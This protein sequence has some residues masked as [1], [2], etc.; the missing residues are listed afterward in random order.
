MGDIRAYSKRQRWSVQELAILSQR[1]AATPRTELASLFPSRD[2]RAV[3]CKAHWLGLA[4]LKA[5][6][7]GTEEVREAKRSHMARKRK[8]NPDAA[9]QYQRQ[10]HEDNRERQIAKMRDYYARRFFWSKAMRLRGAGRA[11]ARELAAIW[12]AQRGRCALTG[13]R[14]DRTAQLDHKTPL[15]RGGGD[16]ASN[17][18]WL[19]GAVNQSKRAL[20]DAEFIALCGDVMLWIGRRIERLA[21]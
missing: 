9:R 5:P 15:S 7:R 18:Q 2:I 21:A 16:D 12:K 17:L 6:P 13:R 4:R 14:L 8:E 20:T 11:T 3:E 1:Y 10:F 19:C